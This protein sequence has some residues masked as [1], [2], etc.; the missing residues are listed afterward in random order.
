MALEWDKHVPD[1]VSV[2]TPIP[3]T[4][5]RLVQQQIPV[6]VTQVVTASGGVAV[7]LPAEF[8]AEI[9]DPSEYTVVLTPQSFDEDTGS[10]TPANKTTSGF[11]VVNS[12]PVYGVTV[13]VVVFWIRS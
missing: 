4:W 11:D 2:A 1:A 3:L 7:S 10:V 8:T 6:L 12:G 5:H 9:S 13:G